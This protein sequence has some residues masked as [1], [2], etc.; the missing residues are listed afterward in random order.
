MRFQLCPASK[1]LLRWKPFTRRSVLVRVLL[2]E[3]FMPRLA[4]IEMPTVSSS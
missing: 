4:S 2:D 1:Q 3:Q